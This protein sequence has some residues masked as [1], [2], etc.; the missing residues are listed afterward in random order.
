MTL[1]EF[2][3]CSTCGFICSQRDPFLRF[4][5]HDNAKLDFK[6]FHL[7]IQLDT[8][9]FRPQSSTVFIIVRSFPSLLYNISVSNIPNIS[10]PIFFTEN[11]S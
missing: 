11:D 4:K 6:R 3:Y 5:I 9:V 8:H 2:K 1:G 10:V 7:D